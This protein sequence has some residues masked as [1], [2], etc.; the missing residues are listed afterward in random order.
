MR[1][2]NVA[3]WIFEALERKEY[4][5]IFHPFLIELLMA[6]SPFLFGKSIENDLDCHLSLCD[7]EGWERGCVVS[8]N[9]FYFFASTSI[10]E[11]RVKMIQGNTFPFLIE[12]LGVSPFSF[13][14]LIPRSPVFLSTARCNCAHLTSAPPLNP[15]RANFP[16]QN[17][18]RV[19]LGAGRDI[20]VSAST[21]PN[22]TEW[23][24]NRRR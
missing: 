10:T 11:N 7:C 13:Q 6:L 14:N 2:G 3:W 12:T 9:V 21:H 4:W 19:C 17:L 1:P 18:V 5:R 16:P 20:S 24:K 22:Q 15:H 8:L 23:M